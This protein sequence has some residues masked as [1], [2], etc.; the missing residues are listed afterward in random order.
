[1]RLCDPKRLEKS[2]ERYLD[3]PSLSKRFLES[4][5]PDQVEQTQSNL[6]DRFLIQLRPPGPER[7]I[8][9]GALPFFQFLDAAGITLSSI[10]M[11]PDCLRE[12]SHTSYPSGVTRPLPSVTRNFNQPSYF[13]EAAP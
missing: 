8:E 5:D 4:P 9:M 12:S 10:S 7:A 11:E 2:I 3:P 13:V 1:M 6:S